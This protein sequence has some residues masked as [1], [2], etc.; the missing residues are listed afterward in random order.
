MAVKEKVLRMVERLP[1]DVTY[2][3]VTYHLEA[4]QESE[5]GL[6]QAERGEVLAHDELMAQLGIEDTQDPPFSR[7]AC[8][9]GSLTPSKLAG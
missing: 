4:M 9:P 7:R 3:R 1:A 5:I 2:D 8:S 6:G